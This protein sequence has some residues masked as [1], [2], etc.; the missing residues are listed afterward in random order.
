M[1]PKTKK[2]R[3]WAVISEKGSFGAVHDTFREAEY[4]C[5]EEEF[6]VPCEITYQLPS[7]KKIK[8]Y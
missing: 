6:V 7:P 4:D 5:F 3:A 2:V 8:H 1:K